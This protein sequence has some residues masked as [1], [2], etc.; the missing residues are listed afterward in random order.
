MQTPDP[1]RGYLQTAAVPSS[2]RHVWAV[3]AKPHSSRPPEILQAGGGRRD[4]RWWRERQSPETEDG[5]VSQW[6]SA[7]ILLLSNRHV[8]YRRVTPPSLQLFCGRKRQSQCRPLLK[9]GGQKQI[10]HAFRP[11]NTPCLS[12]HSEQGPS[13]P[14]HKVP[15]FWESEGFLSLLDRGVTGQ[16]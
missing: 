2:L 13:A 7:M 14:S 16:K 8:S 4:V 3:P 11:Q 5:R 1:H 10:L 15:V 6:R 12:L 9:Y